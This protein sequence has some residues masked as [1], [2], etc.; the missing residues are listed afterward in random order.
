[1]TPLQRL[2][3]AVLI[4][5]GLTISAAARAAEPNLTIQNGYYLV[6]V[7]S[8]HGL[9]TRA[10]DK[11]G[12]LELLQEPRLADNFKFTLPIPGKAAWQATEANYV[13]GKGQRL[14]SHEAGD[15]RLVLHWNAP[16]TSVIGKS[17]DVSAVMTIQLVD[18]DIRFTL[19]IRNA[20]NLDIGEVYYP[21]LG[22]SLGLGTGPDL[23]KQTQLVVPE[24]P[25]VRKENIFHT[26]TNAFWL[27][28][29]GAEQYY[30]Y[31]DRLSM[32]WAELN[33]P[34]LD[35]GVYIG[36][37]DPVA[38]FKVI[39][40]DMLPG[41]AGARDE[42]NWP[43]PEELN[44]LPT[45]VKMSFVHFP[46]QPAG[47]DFEASPI[48]VRFHEGSWREGAGVYRDWLRSQHDM[49]EAARADWQYRTQAFQQCGAVPFNDLPEWARQGAAAGVNGLL[50]TEWKIGG[51]GNGIPRFDPD[52]QMGSRQDLAEAIRKC[53]DLGV[54]VALAVKL[55]PA[56]QLD[57]TYQKELHRYACTDRWGIIYTRSQWSGGSP[58]TG[59]YG[60]SERR[61]WLNPG[62]P[63]MRKYLV[64][65]LRELAALGAD[66][67]H[68]QDFFACPL[69]FNPT[70]GAT[71]DRASWEGGIECV[72]EIVRTCRSVN[73]DFS[74]SMD[75]LWDRMLSVTQIC[76]TEARDSHALLA[77]FP[78][79]QPTFTLTDEDSL[80]AV[81]NSLFHR[82][83]LCIAPANGQPMGGAALA[84]IVGYLETV[85]RV[86]ETLAHT[87]LDGES[88][89]SKGLRVDDS[90]TFNVF[91]NK[92]S[93]LRTAVL[94][95][96]AV[97]AISPEVR[98]F[99]E[100]GGRPMLLWQPG[101]GVSRLDPP[102]RVT[103]P[104]RGLAVVTEE[105][106]YD[107]LAGIPRWAAP[108]RDEAVL[109]DLAS[110]DD[111]R[112]WTLQG[113]AFSVSPLLALGVRSTLNSLAASGE[114]ATGSALSPP[115]TVDSR[116]KELEIVFHGGWSE[117]RNGKENLAVRLLDADSG[118]VLEQVLPPG[119]HILTTRR[120]ALDKLSGKSIRLMLVD[121]NTAS[122]YAWIG[123]RRLSLV[124]SRR[125]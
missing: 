6:E 56:I 106:A 51:A 124:G 121:N 33:H 8:E 75:A 35:R 4:L 64:T 78:F 94:V 92:A 111:L 52:P 112:D 117:E 104:G 59:G 46:Y 110:A 29:L 5:A 125:P 107:R 81:N 118:A 11:R 67:V 16:L 48:V 105:P 63:G 61:V 108:V 69:D 70:V 116:F 30:S 40:L 114:S 44:G 98:G 65:Q 12:K 43:R 123:L 103:I 20:T 96:P 87:L 28:V 102:R 58:L 68:L 47:Q 95:N 53:H 85:L 120:L 34:G 7:D 82:G 90:V 79:V 39:H 73:P 74:V 88:L 15:T 57:E 72:G 37:H 25:D 122:T 31:P 13:L 18:E 62:N 41:T 80:G 49:E 24:E 27:G 77:A 109:F 38:R 50:L 10:Y 17:Y 84:G 115:F 54:K 26:F 1:M 22:G 76:P 86:R 97:N 91:R 71:P 99:A 66:G 83:R 2:E 32:P 100:S 23:R 9:I 45:G 42:G 89:R 14:T 3:W 19:K 101:E 55:Q 119:T 93:G 60:G 113:N 36:A 21:I